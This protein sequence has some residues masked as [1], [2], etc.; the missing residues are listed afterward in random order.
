M[1]GYVYIKHPI[2]GEVIAIVPT[3]KLD[4]QKAEGKVITPGARLDTVWF[5]KEELLTDRTEILPF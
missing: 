1:T 2:T 3:G 4:G 5:T